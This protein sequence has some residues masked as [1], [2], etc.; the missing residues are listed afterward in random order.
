MHWHL[1]SCKR[2]FMTMNTGIKMQRCS[3]P[4]NAAWTGSQYACGCTLKRT[5]ADK[6]CW[7]ASMLRKEYVVA[8]SQIECFIGDF[9]RTIPGTPAEEYATA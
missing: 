1:D 2:R 5:N 3:S 8:S 4:V 7:D 6:I 9:P